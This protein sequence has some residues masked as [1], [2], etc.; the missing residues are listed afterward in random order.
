MQ[1]RYS[2]PKSQSWQC[3]FNYDDTP[4]PNHNI[5]TI[6]NVLSMHTTCYT[7]T[8]PKGT[9]EIKHGYSTTELHDSS[10]AHRTNYKTAISKQRFYV[11][12]LYPKRN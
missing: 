2:L 11:T 12:I 5:R 1:T 3:T 4:A 8:S 10:P 6:R 9:P 7:P